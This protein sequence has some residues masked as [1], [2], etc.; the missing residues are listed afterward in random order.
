M[1]SFGGGGRMGRFTEFTPVGGGM[2][3]DHNRLYQ[4]KLQ[5][6]PRI[7]F[8]F[9]TSSTFPT[10]IPGQDM[11]EGFGDHNETHM[12]GMSMTAAQRD[13]ISPQMIN[14]ARSAGEHTSLL[15]HDVTF[16]VV[17][18]IAALE[19]IIIYSLVMHISNN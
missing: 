14:M 15:R 19:A 9:G 8:G 3:I 6:T 12:N 16:Y 1:P 13:T 17:L 11:F 10:Y 5:Q 18:G 7:R 2:D 4:R